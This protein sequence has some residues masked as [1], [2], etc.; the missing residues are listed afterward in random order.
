MPNWRA[1][2][3]FL[4]SD[5][6]LWNWTKVIAHRRC[7]QTLSSAV[8][9]NTTDDLSILVRDWNA[10]VNACPMTQSQSDRIKPLAGRYELP[11]YFDEFGRMFIDG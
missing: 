6:D 5:P 3:D 8:A 1:F 9:L 2:G 11:V 4:L 10:C 7:Y